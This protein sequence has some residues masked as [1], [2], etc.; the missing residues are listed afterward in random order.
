ML[1]ATLFTLHKS[2]NLKEIKVLLEKACN[3]SL[4][5]NYVAM[6]GAK[7]TIK[8]TVKQVR[9]FVF[10]KYTLECRAAISVNA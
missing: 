9:Y 7:K 3:S 2:S 6:H 4:L 8:F 5:Y 1:P 10:G